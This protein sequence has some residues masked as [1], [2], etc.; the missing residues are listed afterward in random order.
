MKYVL[1]VIS[2]LSISLTPL[3]FAVAEGGG[4]NNDNRT[5]IQ[6]IMA[7]REEQRRLEQQRRQEWANGTATNYET[8]ATKTSAG[9]SLNPNIDMNAP[10]ANQSANAG[11]G[12]NS[13]AGQIAQMVGQAL[14]ATGSAMMGS[15]CGNPGGASCCAKGAMLLGMGILGMI[16]AGQNKS[17]A[18]QH[19]YVGD[20]TY[21]GDNP[22]GS[23]GYGSDTPGTS[24]PF[25]PAVKNKIS[26][27]EGKGFEFNAK[28]GT[29]SIPGGK[30]FKL[31]D[32]TNK[33]AMGNA[34]VSG[35]D[36]AANMATAA[37]LEKKAV[38]DVEKIG[39]HTAS[40][41]MA[42]GGSGGGGGRSVSSTTD[43]SDEVSYRQK[44]DDPKPTV[45]GMMKSYNGEMIGVA[46][47]SIFAM[48]ARRYQQ[49][50]KEESFLPPDSSPAN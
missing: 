43:G 2:I 49:K 45:A 6:E 50:H 16:Q 7:R 30:S 34:G 41:G 17:T 3:T 31:S 39:A 32:V 23:D 9:N 42:D 38:S 25:S 5:T 8:N 24:D 14:Q 37:G 1:R 20:I 40:Q 18:G 26:E 48:M 10:S 19:G 22:Y 4:G 33:D 46:G 11:Q 13:S 21:G 27:L 35:A 12:S 28:N 29:L 15:C 36:Y 44:A 47:D